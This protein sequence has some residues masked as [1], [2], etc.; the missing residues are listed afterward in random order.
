MTP[1]T[2][3]VNRWIK[4]AGFVFTVA[5]LAFAGVLIA[6]H[7]GNLTE[8]W[9]ELKA[10]GWRPRPGW[11][12]AAL[13]VATSNLFL[14]GGAWIHLLRALG[15][16]LGYVEGMRVWTWTN[17]GRYLPGRV[18]QLS[19]LTL[20]L[21]EKRKIGG[22]GL[23]SNLALQVLMLAIGAAVA[24]GVLGLRLA[25]GRPALITAAAVVAV[26]GLAVALRPSMVLRLS[27]L[28]GSWLG[29]PALSAEPRRATL[30][31]AAGVVTVSWGVQGLSLWLLWR[32]AGAEAGPDPL[33]WIGAFAAAY[34]AGYVAVFAPAGLVVR[35]GALAFLL[36]GLG[37]VSAAAAAGI[38]ILSRLLAIASE[39]V[40]AG[41]AWVLPVRGA[42]GTERKDREEREGVP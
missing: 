3:T 2:T 40:A 29:E 22:I 37:D 8:Q 36:V 38:A 18:W 17:L 16:R 5:S 32:G 7:G 6:R 12:F 14:L 28:M 41:L 19:A 34:L 35:E 23:G 1:R 9:V 4:A 21:R 25:E 15:G 10:A 39:L 30:W 42:S 33:F 24:F 31:E 13:V 11:L 27:N 26:G 20:Y